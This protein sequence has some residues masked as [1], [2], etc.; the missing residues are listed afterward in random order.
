M[1]NWIRN[2]LGSKPEPLKASAIDRAIVADVMARSGVPH[3]DARVADRIAVAARLV[4]T[5][6]DEQADAL[7]I[8][9]DKPPVSDTERRAMDVELDRV[10]DALS[11]ELVQAGSRLAGAAPI[12]YEIMRRLRKQDDRGRP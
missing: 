8:T 11:D 12:G 9:E 4:I 1:F 5:T 3:P 7:E 6:V 10:R 2:L